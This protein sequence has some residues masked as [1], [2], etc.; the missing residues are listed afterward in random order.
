MLLQRLQHLPRSVLTTHPQCSQYL[1][2]DRAINPHKLYPQSNKHLQQQTHEI[3]KV[4][5]TYRIDHCGT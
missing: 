2:T 1:L 3:C 4:L 5:Q